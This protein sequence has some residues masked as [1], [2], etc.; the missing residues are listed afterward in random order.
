MPE[1][2]WLW[3][4]GFLCVFA[5][6]TGCTAGAGTRD[7]GFAFDDVTDRAGIDFVHER[8]VFDSKAANIM[9]WLSATGAGVFVAD[10]DQD[11]WMD[12]YFTNSKQGSFNALYR[13]NGDG[14]FTETGKALGVDDVNRTGVSETALWFDY[15]NDGYPDLFVG[16]WSGECRLF[17]N[18]GDGT[19][20][21]ITAVSGIGRLKGNF[22][23][24]IALDYDRDGQLDL[25]L[26]AYF[27]EETDMFHMDTT[28][29]M[30]N[31]FEM[32]RNGG[33]NRLLRNGDGVFQ[34]VTDGMGVADTG[35][36]LATG[37]ADINDDGWPD[38]YN[39]NDFGPDTLYINQAGKRFVSV[40]QTRGVGEDTY[41]GMNVDF[42]DVFHDGRLAFY[43]TNVSKPTY[44]LEGNQLWHADEQGRFVDRAPDMNVQFADFSW[45]A[46]FFDVDNSG[47]FSLAVATGFVSASKKRDYWFDLGTLATTPGEVIAD[48]KNWMPF[49]DKSLS[50]YEHSYLFWNNG[51]VFKDVAKDVGIT[52]DSDSRGVAAADLSNRGL[53]DLVFANQG[54]APKLY[55][56]KGAADGR[57]W[58]TLNLI[59]TYPSNRDAVGA[60]VT[61]EVGGV[62]T[63]M[64]RD[65]GNSHG[66][67][68]DPRIHFGLGSNDRV[69]KMTI[70]WPSGRVQTFTDVPADR[71]Q[72]VREPDEPL[73]VW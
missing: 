57:H 25:Y 4:A 70:R 48:T 17:E 47:N 37:S 29:I 23:K 54:A 35:W 46:R 7:Y 44:I 40:A 31:D 63:V 10:Y 51:S 9:P 49:E 27:R 52:F 42:A 69:D 55:R 56:H 2:K 5:I 66:A 24:A 38:I 22:I 12:L 14:T 72:V 41:K 36:T 21:D 64:E 39:A 20:R 30:Q 1:R 58:I 53:T 71:I 45:G 50:G 61:F 73:E 28:M 6:L 60:R 11:G 33:K 13:N 32:A 3:F 15:N 8:P 16:Q 19:F 34:D 18:N 67:Q 65:G 68:S 43:V 59:G 26:A 62:R